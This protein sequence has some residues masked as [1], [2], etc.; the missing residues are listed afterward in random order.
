[1]RG[2]YTQRDCKNKK[3]NLNWQFFLDKLLKI[4]KKTDA[5][6]WIMLHHVLSRFSADSDYSTWSINAAEC[7]VTRGE[8]CDCMVAMPHENVP[9]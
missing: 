5:T 4:L 7:A 9:S 1:M 8:Y 2:E 6:Y 3:K